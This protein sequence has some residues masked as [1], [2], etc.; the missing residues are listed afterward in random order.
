VSR[1]NT[2]QERL[3]EFLQ[4]IVAQ[5]GCD[6]E[7]V[8]LSPSG[9]R[10]QLRI[11]VDRDGGVT[12]DDL[13]GVT[14]EVSKAFDA[15]DIMGELIGDA[16]YTMEISSP[17]VDRPLTL[18]RHWRRNVGRLVSVALTAGDKFKGR[19]LGAGD[20]GVQLDVDGEKRT[21]GYDDVA[22]AKVEV[23]FNR[24]ADPAVEV[25]PVEEA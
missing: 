23:E 7:S 18:P 2:D 24:K 20:D 10:R 1:S 25:D 5:F 3:E 4:P 6:L 14:R 21:V 13:A 9:R 16:S 15:Q 11:L 19:I 22:K 17:G 12:M 8:E